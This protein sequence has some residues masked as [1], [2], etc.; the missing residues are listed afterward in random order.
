MEQSGKEAKQDLT[1]IRTSF[2][3][4]VGGATQLLVDRIRS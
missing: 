2:L 1:R 4:A 3:E